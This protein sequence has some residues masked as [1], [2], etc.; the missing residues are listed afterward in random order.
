MMTKMIDMY[1]MYVRNIRI[2]PRVGQDEGGIGGTDIFIKHNIYVILY[3]NATYTSR[4]HGKC[5][6]LWNKKKAIIRNLELYNQY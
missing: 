5:F 3:T 4:S 6:L 2:R 1:R